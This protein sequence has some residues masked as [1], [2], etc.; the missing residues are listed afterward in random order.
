MLPSLHKREKE[1]M[2]DK[3]M[4]IR[5]ING[6]KKLFPVRKSSAKSV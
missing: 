3:I 2:T 6:N 5:M 4:I 1:S